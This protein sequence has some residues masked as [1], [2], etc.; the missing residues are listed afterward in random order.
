MKLNH[1][2]GEPSWELLPYAWHDL[3][4]E[5][6]RLGISLDAERDSFDDTW[7]KDTDDA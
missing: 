6:E 3:N 2:D 4:A 1:Q 5:F 7:R